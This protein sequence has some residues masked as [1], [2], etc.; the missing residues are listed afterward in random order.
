MDTGPISDL[1]IGNSI[2]V[3]DQYDT[4]STGNTLQGEC[5][6]CSTMGRSN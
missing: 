4:T 6:D 2:N 1:L 5:I 3:F